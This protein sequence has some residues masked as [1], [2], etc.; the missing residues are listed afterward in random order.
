MASINGLQTAGL[1]VN[2]IDGLTT[3]YAT[4]IYDNGVLVDPTAPPIYQSTPQV[5]PVSV[6]PFLR[7]T[8][9]LKQVLSY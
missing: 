3:L 1:Q 6:S 2:T 5:A 9:V 4:S 8:M 7:P